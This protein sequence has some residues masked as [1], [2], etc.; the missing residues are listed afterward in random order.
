M[1]ST[2][3][4]R[5]RGATLG[6]LVGAWLLMVVPMAAA[7][8]V[9]SRWAPWIGCWRAVDETAAAAFTATATASAEAPLLCVVPLAGE[10]AIEML[11]VVDGQ[12]VSRES[13]FT[14]G[15]QHGVSREECEGWEG[16]EFSADSHRIYVRSELTCAAGSHRSSTGL[17]SMVSPFEWLDVRTMDVDGQ[18]V[19]WAIRYR[20]ASQAD[21]E[22]AGQEDLFSAQG[23]EVRMARMVASIPIVVDDVIE[24]AGRVSAETLQLWVVERGE[25]FALDASRLIEMADAGVPPGVIDVVVAVSYPEKFV[26]NERLSAGPRPGEAVGGRSSLGY[27]RGLSPFEDPF[28]DPYSRYGYYSHYGSRYPYGLG[29]YGGFGYGPGFYLGYGYGYGGYGYGFGGYYGG[30]YGPPIVVV[31]RRGAGPTAG[32]VV[33]GGGYTSAGGSGESTGRSARPRSSGSSRSAAPA[34]RSAR[35]GSSRSAAPA[36]RSARPRSSGGG[37]VTRSAAP[38]RSP[39]TRSSPRSSGRS[40]RPRA[41]RGN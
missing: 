16:A 6:V 19:P 9:D 33:R 15:R 13:I 41:G 27:G 29:Y 25:P 34:A 35:P 26:V 21:F 23:S 37:S 39:A 40:A 4:D 38:S 12:V 5:Q 17:M 22:A 11:T 30:G 8:E 24:A 14:D 7:Q 3:N 36:A 20:L 2:L 10:A 18:S 1:V 31:G 32:R 28:Y